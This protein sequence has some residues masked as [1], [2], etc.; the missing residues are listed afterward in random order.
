MYRVSINYSLFNTSLHRG[1]L[2]CIP[3]S[4]LDLPSTPRAGQVIPACRIWFNLVLS[5]DII[6]K[7]NLSLITGASETMASLISEVYSC[8]VE[9]N[10][11]GKKLGK[12]DMGKYYL[13][14]FWM[15][16][17]CKYAMNYHNNI[18]MWLKKGLKGYFILKC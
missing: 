3:I 6:F 14:Q 4:I 1:I 15:Q 18:F 9:K 8:K 11:I 12:R 16:F 5:Q 13:N 17:C 2:V 10:G 7:P